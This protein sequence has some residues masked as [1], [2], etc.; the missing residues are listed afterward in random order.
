[1][2]CISRPR[3]ESLSSSCTSSRRHVSPLMAYS[4]APL[5]NSVREI[6][7]SLYSIGSAPSALSIV[8]L[9]SARPSGPRVDGAGEDDVL[10]LAAA[11]R[12]GALLAH[13]PGE[14]VDDVRL[15]RAVGADDAGDARFERERRRLRE[16]LEALERQALEVHV[17]PSPARENAADY[18]YPRFGARAVARAPP[19]ARSALA[20]PAR[21]AIVWAAARRGGVRRRRWRSRSDRSPSRPARHA[22]CRRVRGLRGARRA[23]E[24]SAGATTDLRRTTPHELLAR[25]RDERVHRGQAFARVATATRCVGRVEVLVGARRR[26][27]DGRASRHGRRLARRAPPGHRRAAARRAEE[28]ARSRP[29][30]SSRALGRPP[31]RCGSTARAAAPRARRRRR[32][33]RPTRQRPI[34]RSRT[35]TRSA[36]SNG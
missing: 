25:Y 15:A 31:D 28:A 1:M 2:T 19:P 3:P 29:V 20:A 21:R 4:L 16:G 17:P 13:D 26:R 27:R 10:H 22:R 35:A 7:T 23:L 6:V 11:Q 8:R 14:R 24:S 18:A 36:S 5:R 33:S 32:R 34:R 12:L 30:D 9:T